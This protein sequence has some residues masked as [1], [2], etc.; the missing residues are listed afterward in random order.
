M[1]PRLVD[2]IGS[3][4][5][6]VMLPGLASPGVGDE[7]RPGIGD[8]TS[9][10]ATARRSIRSVALIALARA[11][12]ARQNARMEAPVTRPAEL[13]AAT[14]ADFVTLHALHARIERHDR[15]P[16]ST[17]LEEF[18]HWADDPHLVMER[19]TRV[20][21][22][23]G[24]MIG[25]AR[26]WF[27]PSGSREERAYVFG[28]VAP[29]ARG[30]GTGTRLMRFGLQRS[31][32]ILLATGGSLPL[33]VRTHCYDFQHEAIR[34][35][36]RHGMTPVRY[37][38]EMKRDLANVPDAALPAGVA[39]V[40]WDRARD[41]EAREV[42]NRSFED[43]WGATPRGPE[44]WAHDLAAFGTRLD[45]SFQAIEAGR[46]IGFARNEYFPGDE[47]VT[48]EK[49]GWIGLLGT[50]RE[51][52]KRG[53]ASALIAASL[54]AFVGA[55]FT[56]AALGV[57]SANPTGAHRLYENLGFHVRVRTVTHQLQ[58]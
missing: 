57:D 38:Q 44:V 4:F 5:V 45:L 54:R 52:R 24:V 8:C 36:R 47:A 39:I 20:A 55:G 25:W 53:V 1:L 14:P 12:V 2:P 49:T 28:G 7:T 43:H 22:M 31:K 56:H 11:R 33:Y 21:E 41:E 23:D 27:R 32:Q 9:R 15:L 18:E 37:G 35:Y 3:V 29:E 6:V 17:P 13:R 58:V 50:L 46:M 48:G 42:S 51:H 40:P 19:D 30:R 26:V 16:L 34:L 10:R